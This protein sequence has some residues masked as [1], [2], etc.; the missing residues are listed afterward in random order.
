MSVRETILKYLVG[1]AERNEQVGSNDK[2]AEITGC[3]ASNVSLAKT[4][5]LKSG[6]MMRETRDKHFR[7]YFPSIGKGTAW[8]PVKYVKTGRTTRRCMCCRK[9][10]KSEGIHN[11]MCKE[12]GQRSEMVTHTF[13]PLR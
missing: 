9:P 13:V 3:Q 6:T 1:C 5:L 11:R 10:F 8:R 2:I 12:C 4:H 7:Y